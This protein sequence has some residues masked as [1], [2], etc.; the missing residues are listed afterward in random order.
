MYYY[1]LLFYVQCILYTKH[2]TLFIVH[3]TS[4]NV[5]FRVNNALIM[6]YIVCHAEQIHGTTNIVRRMYAKTFDEL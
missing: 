5:Q 4:Y 1:Y 6:P 3:C 2:C